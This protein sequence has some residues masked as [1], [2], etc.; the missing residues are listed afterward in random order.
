MTQRKATREDQLLETAT[1]LFREKGY[2]STS[3]QDLADALA[4]NLPP[5]E[6]LRRALQNHAVTVW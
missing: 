6:K 3:V 2:H 5:P 1:R 4:A